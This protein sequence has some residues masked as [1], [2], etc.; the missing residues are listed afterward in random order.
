MPT[1]V[2]VV[3]LGLTACAGMRELDF[4]TGFCADELDRCYAE[5]CSQVVDPV[6]CQEECGYQAR[7]CEKK[8]GTEG[9]PKARLGEDQASLLDLRGKKAMHS[10]ALQVEHGGGVTAGDGHHTLAPGA[11]YTLNL[12]LPPDT[13]QAEVALTHRPGGAPC[14]ITLTAGSGTL[15][16][17][18]QPPR[19]ERM[20]AEV[21][22]FTKFLPK[23]EPGA[24]VPI[25]LTVFNN[26][27]AGSKVPYHLAEVQ[28][29]YRVMEAPTFR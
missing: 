28:V 16:G 12:T 1:R 15:L 29:F 20:K 6:P 22:D 18:Y 27:A 5:Q 13:R 25:T 21:F 8:Q 7:V 24:P 14:Y 19:S 9:K 10:S 17:R 2:W 3:A 11:F 26:D 23:V 4:V